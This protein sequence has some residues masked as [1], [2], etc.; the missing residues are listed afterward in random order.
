MKL[1]F[2][3]LASGIY[4]GSIGHTFTPS[5]LAK[6]YLFYPTWT[7]HY[8]CSS[9]YFTKRETF[10]TLLLMY[11]EKGRFHVEYRNKTAIAVKGD[12]ILLD[13]VEPHYYHAHEG[14]EF[15]FYGFEGGNSR[16]MVQQILN[17]RGF[18]IRSPNNQ[19]ISKLLKTTMDYYEKHE[20][21][22]PYEAS[23]RIYK[24]LMLLMSQRELYQPIKN[25]PVEQCLVYIHDNLNRVITLEELAKLVNLTSPYLSKIFKQEMGASPREYILN[26]RMNKA[27][28]LLAQT[29]KT[30]SE[31]ALET[32][33]SNAS[34]FTNLFTE[35]IGCSPT[36][37]RKLISLKS[38]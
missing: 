21:E 15:F 3:N 20:I 36:M 29:S 9:D 38:F 28:L 6:D 22:N 14:L 8:Y 26:T 25:N 12:L 1:I 34:S 19:Q 27:K 23:M 33:Y 18:L 5:R 13:C 2:E 24:L 37:F 7:G 4:T 11:V 17:T 10:P 30:I 31:I 35:N 16:D 32:G